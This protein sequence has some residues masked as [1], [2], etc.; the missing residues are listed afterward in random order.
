MSDS[1]RALGNGP[2]TE[3]R[4]TISYD[5]EVTKKFIASR[6][7]AT[8][9][10]FFLPHLRSGMSLLDCGCGPGSITVGFAETVAPGQV[11]GIDLSETQTEQAGA[12]AREKGIDNVRFDVASI[13]ELPFSDDT[14]DAAF[15]H[16]VFLHLAEPQKALKEMRRVLKPGGVVG[17][18]E[19]GDGGWLNYSHKHE[20]LMKQFNRVLHQWGTATSGC[21]MMI[22]RRLRGLFNQVGFKDVQASASFESWGTPEGVEWISKIGANLL[23]EQNFI[24]GVTSN[25][26]ADH[27]TVGRIRD[28]F[29]EMSSED[30]AFLAMSQVEAVG[31]KK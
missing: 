22:G 24:D 21:D 2:N 8:H 28:A 16:H 29:I 5:S 19:I 10:S 20:E 17:V 31:W 27:E 4:Y 7:A 15:A 12:L 18:K 30:D 14:F 13:Y 3:R 23:M 11:I 26:I 1:T 9:A 25:G 6:T